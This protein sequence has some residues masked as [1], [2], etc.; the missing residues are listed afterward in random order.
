VYRI[1]T[2]IAAL[3]LLL[4]GCNLFSS[5]AEKPKSEPKQ[6]AQSEKMKNPQQTE[7]LSAPQQAVQQWMQAMIDCDAKTAVNLMTSETD[8]Q[9][10]TQSS[11]QLEQQCKQDPGT[12]MGG[13]EQAQ[14]DPTKSNFFSK[15]YIAEVPNQ[16]PES[17]KTT[18]VIS[19]PD[20]D[21]ADKEND[22]MLLELVK[23]NG[24]WK[25]DVDQFEEKTSQETEQEFQQMYQS[26][27]SQFKFKRFP[28]QPPNEM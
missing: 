13:G 12:L 17:E 18:Q 24:Q 20:G 4:S 11:S 19:G 3:S 27:P 6:P 28:I 21:D 14:F 22:V 26:N 8:P 2:L 1:I 10:E 25:I 16:L 23:V 9:Y 7:T 15:L 5:D